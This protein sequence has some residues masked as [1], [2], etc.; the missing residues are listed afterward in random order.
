MQA[1]KKLMPSDERL[2]KTY[3][4]WMRRAEEEA[5]AG[6]EAVKQVIVAPEEFRVYCLQLG[7][8]P[9]YSVLDALAAKKAREVGRD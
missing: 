9:N 8:V 2:G 3:T 5:R 7:Q 4:E 1:F 6:D